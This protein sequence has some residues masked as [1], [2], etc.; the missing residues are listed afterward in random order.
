MIT[1]SPPKLVRNLGC[2]AAAGLL[3]ALPARA[4]NPAGHSLITADDPG[5]VQRGIEEAYRSG[6]KTVVI[7][8]GVYR[9]PKPEQGNSHLMFSDMKDFTIDA[10]GV[11]FIPTERDKRAFL[12]RNSENVTLQGA[13]FLREVPP[14]SQGKIE[15]VAADRSS[16]DIRIDKG[17]PTD[18][19]DVRYFPHIPSISLFRTGTQELKPLVPYLQ[20]AKI[21]RLGP[22]LFRFQFRAALNPAIPVAVGDPAAWRGPSGADLS[23]WECA[24]MRFK[25]VTVKNGT[26]LTFFELAGGGGNHYEHCVIT[27]APPPPGAVDPPLLASGTDGFH[28]AATRLGPTLED[29]HFEGLDDDAVNIHGTYAMLMEAKGK[30][31]IVDWRTPH[32]G[33]RVPLMLGRPGD[34]V[35]IYDHSAALQ[36]EANI[37]ALRPKADYEPGNLGLVASRVFIHRDKAVYY[38]VDLD[39]P[40]TGEPGGFVANPSQVGGGFVIRNSTFRNSRGHGLFIRAGD[41]L[42]EGCTVEGIA[43]AGIVI[44]PEMNSWNEADYARHVVV[45]DNVIR[46]VGFSTQPW[47]SGG[48]GGGVRVQ[49]LRA[50]TRRPP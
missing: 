48:D 50:A 33:A 47:N 14:F 37:V 5:S 44:A 23:V 18:L 35:R 1:F 41:G 34:P 7:P 17:Y 6:A 15:T 13:T 20:V 11:T 36:A 12:I 25:D 46:N 3:G 16:A 26:G 40:V 45:Q 42:I 27:Y 29:C 2:V 30:T 24:H 43:M 22:D 39:R 8:A 49:P 38:E 21:E 32:T 28:S 31:L 9:L 19:D 10:T 4:A